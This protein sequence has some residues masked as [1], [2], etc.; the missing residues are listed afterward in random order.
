MLPTLPA[1]EL[2]LLSCHTALGSS[3]PWQ[4]PAWHST[5]RQPRSPGKIP[6]LCFGFLQLLAAP[7]GP[8]ACASGWTYSSALLFSLPCLRPAPS[9]APSHEETCRCAEDQVPVKSE[10]GSVPNPVWHTQEGMLSP[11]WSW[12][13]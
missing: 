8:T 5:G 4:L 11:S 1:Q 10:V 7:G 3:L 13:T 9:S 2:S 12:E 6:N